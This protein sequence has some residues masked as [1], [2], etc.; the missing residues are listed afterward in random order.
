M[1][2]PAD[3]SPCRGHNSGRHHD[4]R[5]RSQR[6]RSVADGRREG[7]R[8]DVKDPPCFAAG[9]VVALSRDEVLA[10]FGDTPAYW[11]YAGDADDCFNMLP[12]LDRQ[13]ALAL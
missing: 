9:G 6:C 1:F 10:K 7:R 2:Q 11:H 8:F 5:G 4:L 13:L 3:M 12:T